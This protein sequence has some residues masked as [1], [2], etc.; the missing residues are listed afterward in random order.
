M[1]LSRNLPAAEAGGGGVMPQES[2]FS[3][4][5]PFVSL[6]VKS[7]GWSC[8]GCGTEAVV[9]GEPQFANPVLLTH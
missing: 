5:S 1:R 2:A 7:L 9:P 6:A 3:V 4:T 8:V